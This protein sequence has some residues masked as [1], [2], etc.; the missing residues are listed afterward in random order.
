MVPVN[1]RLD[2][3]YGRLVSSAV[4]NEAFRIRLLVINEVSDDAAIMLSVV[5]LYKAN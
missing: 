3:Q 4:V 1:C 5:N 2:G